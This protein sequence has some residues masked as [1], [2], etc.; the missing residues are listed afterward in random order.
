[1]IDITNVLRRIYEKFSDDASRVVGCHR[2]RFPAAEG[3]HQFVLRSHHL[4]YKAQKKTIKEDCWSDLDHGQ[5]R[6]TEDLFGKPMLLLLRACGGRVNAHLG[7]RHL[8]NVYEC[9]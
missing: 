4:S 9:L 3:E 6:P 5:C 8:R 1:M 7:D 2:R